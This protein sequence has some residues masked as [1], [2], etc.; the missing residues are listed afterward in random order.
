MIQRLK[1]RGFEFV[2]VSELLKESSP[3]TASGLT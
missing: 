3:A 2:T 1:N